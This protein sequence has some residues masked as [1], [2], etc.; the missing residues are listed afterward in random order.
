[1]DQSSKIKLL[2]DMQRIRSMEEIC[3]ELYTLE[4]IRGFLHLYCGQE[5]IASGVIGLLSN[6]DNV[7]GTYREHAHA[8]MK[9]ISAKQIFSEMFGKVEGCSRGRGG[10]MHLYSLSNRFFGGNA[11][12]SSGIPQAVGLAFAAKHLK[13]NRKTVCF[14]GE[15]AMAEGAFHESMNMASLWKIPILFCCEN[16][17][18][19]MGT[20]LSRSQSEIN[21]VKKVKPYLIEADSVDGMN[22]LEVVLKTKQALKYIEEEKKPFFLEFKT[23]RF[24]AHSMF[25]PELYRQKSEVVKWKE[26]DPIELLKKN[27]FENLNESEKIIIMSALENMNH[28]ISLEMKEAVKFAEDGMLESFSELQI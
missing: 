18:Y 7:I 16:N 2:K 9:G 4:K 12:V 23:Y 19:A 13:E 22:V 28:E 20:A 10:S 27:L 17:L 11:I 5:A 24:R 6:D 8:L 21:L 26:R 25:D 1:M 15:G 14:F 3:A